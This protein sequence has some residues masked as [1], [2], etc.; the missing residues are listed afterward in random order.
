M[1]LDWRKN[2]LLSTLQLIEETASIKERVRCDTAASGKYTSLIID[3]S[4]RNDT[5]E[6]ML[7][8]TSDEGIESATFVVKVI[9]MIHITLLSHTHR[10]D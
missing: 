3:K 2:Y 10:H 1:F 8:L 5:G 9:G 4:R 6:Y 7:C